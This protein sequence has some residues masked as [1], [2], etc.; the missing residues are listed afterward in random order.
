[1]FEKVIFNLLAYSLFIIIFFKIIRKDD[2]NYII[3]LVLQGLGIAVSFIEIK[4]GIN[5]NTFFKV[6]RYI[7]SVILPIVVI[8]LELKDINFSEILSLCAARFLMIFGDTKTSKSILNKMVAKYPDSYYGHKLLAAIYEKE[9]GMRKAID[10]YV[11]SIDLKKSDYNSYYKISELLKDLG[12]KDE[13]IEMLEKLVRNKPDMYEASCLLGDLLCE[14][15]RFK[16]AASVYESALKF[17]PADYELYY[18][19]GIVY[20]RLNDFQMAKDMYERAASINHKLWGAKY[21]LGQIALIEKEYILAEQYF[22]ES[23]YDKKLEANSYYQLARIYAG[24][25]EKDKALEFLNKAI[26]IDPRLLKKAGKEKVFKDIRELITVSVKMDENIE[27]DRQK[28]I[29]DEIKELEE[30]HILILQEKEAQEYL[31]ETNYLIED[32]NENTIKQRTADRVNNIITQEKLKHLQEKDA[33]EEML[34]SIEKEGLERTKQ[35]D[36]VDDKKE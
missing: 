1:L 9:G 12:K 28:E 24:R 25:G 23:L 15:E 3:L 16:E 31:E 2:S 21:S 6:F 11:I 22:K 30:S 13:A 7:F 14:Q 27:T 35:D 34:N 18:N 29:E 19:L 20:T 8:Y 5:A 32:M 10:E 17:R 33:Y 4:T 36:D 26:E